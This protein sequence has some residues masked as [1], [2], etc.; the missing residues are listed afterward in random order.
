MLYHHVVH[1]GEM[2]QTVPY[3]GA[4]MRDPGA[5]AGAR[6]KGACVGEGGG[7]G[8]APCQYHVTP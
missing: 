5:G 7:G 4:E 1:G 8:S 3:S 2:M 6:V